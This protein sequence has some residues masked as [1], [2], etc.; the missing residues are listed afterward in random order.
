[1]HLDTDFKGKKVLVIGRQRPVVVFAGSV[2]IVKGAFMLKTGKTVMRS[3][4]L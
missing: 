4:K 3:Q 2:D 1:M